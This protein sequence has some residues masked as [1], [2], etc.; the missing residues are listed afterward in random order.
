MPPPAAALPLPAPPSAADPKQELLAA[1][2]P[3]IDKEVLECVLSTFGGDVEAA[4]GALLDNSQPSNAPAQADLDEAMARQ[5]QLEI[6]DQVAILA[7]LGRHPLARHPEAAII[8][9]SSRPL[10]FHLAPV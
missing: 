5:A 7:A 10:H 8:C 3:E 4:V 1:M 2:F 6:D 9:N